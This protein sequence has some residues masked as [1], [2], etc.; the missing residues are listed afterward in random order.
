MK[1]AYLTGLL[2]YHYNRRHAF[3][4]IDNAVF[5]VL[6]LCSILFILSPIKLL[7]YDELG[8]EC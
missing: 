3:E 5:T 8:T 2:G 1:W 6:S 7:C 4:R